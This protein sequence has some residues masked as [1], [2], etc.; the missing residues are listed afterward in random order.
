M[1]NSIKL[2]LSLV[3]ESTAWQIYMSPYLRALSG[4]GK[5]DPHASG[6]SW[7]VHKTI[8]MKA[9]TAQLSA[10]IPVPKN[11]MKPFQRTSTPQLVAAMETFLINAYNAYNANTNKNRKCNT[12]NDTPHTHTHTRM[13]V[14]QANTDRCK[15]DR[16]HVA[17]IKRTC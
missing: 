7:R 16:A 4:Y 11:P 13:C 1:K 9:T 6:S 17:H 2:E 5:E 12:V 15:T 14:I 10:L 3:P 8:F